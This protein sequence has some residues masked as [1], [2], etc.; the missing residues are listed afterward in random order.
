M[1]ELSDI[2]QASVN[3]KRLSSV[4]MEK[5]AVAASMTLTRQPSREVRIHV[6]VEG[7]TVSTGSFAFAGST[8][9]TLAFTANGEKITTKGYTSVSGITVAGVS[10]GFI[11][12]RAMDKLGNPVNQE[13]SIYSAL[14]VRFY[15]LNGKI[16]MIAAGQTNTAEYK[17]MIAPD[18]LVEASDLIYAVSGIQGLTRGII[19]F[20]TE[21]MDLDGVTH[22]IEC[23]IL[24]L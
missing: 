13:I 19:D 16:R 10:N 12:M 24:G 20:A 4:L 7:A 1:S 15:A 11:T 9:E 8:T 18:K 6:A 21:I 23:D 3:I 14:P 17:M 5:T 2:L 22:H